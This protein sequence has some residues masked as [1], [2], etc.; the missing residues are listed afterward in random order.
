LVE[1]GE[2][3]AAVR[4]HR[5]RE[6]VRRLV[7]LANE[8]GGPDNISVVV[9]DPNPSPPSRQGASG[10]PVAARQLW[11]RASGQPWLLVAAAAV[12]LILV[13]ACVA[14]LLLGGSSPEAAPTDLAVVPATQAPQATSTLAARDGSTTEITATLPLT[15]TP[16]SEIRGVVNTDLVLVVR[17]RPSQF[18]GALDQLQPGAQIQ[19]LCRTK[20]ELVMGD[21][22]WY[23]T[24]VQGGPKGYVAAHWIR[25]VDVQRADVPVCGQ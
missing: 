11:S 12:V 18:S 2:I 15:S 24:P 17:A 25:L 19:V 3:E 13:L 10:L 14:A 22:T 6:A 23:Q 9:L 21:D 16:P 4:Q 7:E 20:G 8:R 1:D 5:P